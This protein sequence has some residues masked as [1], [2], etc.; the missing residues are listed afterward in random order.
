MPIVYFSQL[1]GLALGISP[2]KLGLD[3]LMIPVQ[4]YKLKSK[5]E[6]VAV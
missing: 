6:R 5:I 3:I 1:L 4:D 2:A